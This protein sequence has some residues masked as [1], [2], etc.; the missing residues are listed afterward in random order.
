M[1]YLHVDDEIHLEKIKFSHARLVFDTINRDRRY[2]RE[3][4]PFV[5]QTRKPEDTEAFIRQIQPDTE[6][7]HDNVYIIWYKGDFAG[8]A[9]FKD[10]DYINRKTE[11]GYWLAE[12]MQGKGIMIRTV[13]KLVDFAFR[14]LNH[15]RVQIKVAAGNEKSEAIP[16]KLDFMLEGTERNGEF[17]GNHFHDLKIYSFLKKEW[18]EQLI[19]RV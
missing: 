13:R 4:L 15:N 18:A 2:L 17:H 8:L 3:W 5:D 12:Q 6:I 11:I 10:S 19:R 9:G 16:R 7:R 1:E 14:N